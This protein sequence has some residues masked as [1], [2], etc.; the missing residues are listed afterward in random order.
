MNY[1]LGGSYQ[2]TFAIIDSLG[3]ATNAD[4]TPTVAVERNGSA[5]GTSVTV[6]HPATGRYRCSITL[7]ADPTWINGDNI[8]LIVAATIG[9]NA[10]TFPL[11]GFVAGFV[12]ADNRDGEAIGA[13]GDATEANQLALLAKLNPA[14]NIAVNPVA[15]DLNI[16]LHE[17]DDYSASD[18]GR[19]LAWS[20]TDVDLSG[21]TGVFKYISQASYEADT[22][23]FT[24]A[25]T[26]SIA[27]ADGVNAISVALTAAETAAMTL[28][29]PPKN[30]FAYYYEIDV[31]LSGRVRTVASGGM[32]VVRGA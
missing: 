19:A 23:T 7:P 5:D 9:G 29:T 21:G 13:G 8:E 14:R 30:K 20:I 1:L 27:Y 6:A 24:E 18:T 17:G 3:V 10:I 12:R 16:T 32:G 2:F 4:S 22:G 26:V 28:T 11:V 15:Q 31:T 25:G